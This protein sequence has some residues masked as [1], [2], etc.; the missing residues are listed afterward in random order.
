MHATGT[1]FATAAFRILPLA[2]AVMMALAPAGRAQAQAQAQAPADP[3]VIVLINPNSNASATES[4]A[5]LAQDAAGGRAR[6][7]G[8][9]NEDAPG[10]LTTPGDMARAAG[11]V[12]E[13]G[14]QAADRDDADAIIVSAFSD[15]G[16]AELRRARPGLP[17]V[18]IGEEAFHEAARGGRSFAIVTITPDPALVESFRAKAEALGYLA[19]F[20]GVQVTPGDPNEIVE[21]PRRLDAALAEAVTRAI[22]ENGADAVIMGGG[23]LS[24]PA[25]R[26][27][28]QFDIPLVVAVTAATRA[29]LERIGKHSE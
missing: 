15:P 13:I 22:G 29:A 3:P 25:L 6:V 8:R 26:I 28:P 14:L 5:R 19:Q 24:A 1:S 16:L 17:V 23:P 10:L 2:A 21:D 12:T 7:V 9:T 4:M 27:Q 20:R 18:G 11:C